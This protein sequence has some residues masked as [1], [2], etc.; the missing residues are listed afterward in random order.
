MN[1]TINDVIRSSRTHPLGKRILPEGIEEA[2]FISALA[3][4]ELNCCELG[5]DEEIKE[6][7]SKLPR[8]VVYTLGMMIYVQYLTRELSRIE[9]LNGFHSKDIQLTG[10]DASKRITYNDLVLEIERY[11]IL[12]HKHMV[13]WFN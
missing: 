3:E 8:S 13:H 9:K 1:T 4:Y 11:Q 5:Y 10:S 7:D 12:I 2:W 6:F